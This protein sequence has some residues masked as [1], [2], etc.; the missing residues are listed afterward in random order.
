MATSRGIEALCQAVVE[1]LRDN[2]EPTDF[3]QDLEFRVL[4]DGGFGQGLSAGVSLFLYRVLVNAADR[5][6][7]GRKTDAGDRLRSQLPLDL[8]FLL[9]AWGKDAS[10]QQSIVGW[11]MRIL[12][13][14]TV[15]APG[16]LNR[17]TDDVFRSD[18]TVEIGVAELP[19]EDLLHLW[20]LLGTGTYHLSVPYVARNVRIESQRVL[21]SG[22]LVQDRIDHYEPSVSP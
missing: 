21:V 2:Y 15:L 17:R 9:T 14:H 20:E 13:D 18:E 6:P 19:T 3:N 10:L 1:L 11:M 22:G 12:E 8:H 16:L 7:P 5:T 4:S